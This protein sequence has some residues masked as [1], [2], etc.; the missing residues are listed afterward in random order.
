MS[1]TKRW[2][3]LVLWAVLCGCATFEQ[4]PEDLQKKLGSPT[5][6]RRYE[7]TSGRVVLRNRLASAAAHC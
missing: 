4:T 7:R 1:G 3:G 2:L 5:K 6:G